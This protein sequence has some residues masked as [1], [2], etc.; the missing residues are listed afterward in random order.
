M[1]FSTSF[2]FTN[3]RF[4]VEGALYKQRSC[5]G[6]PRPKKI[7]DCT[8][9]TKPNGA[10]KEVYDTEHPH[11]SIRSVILAE[12]DMDGVQCIALAA[13]SGNPLRSRID[14]ESPYPSVRAINLITEQLVSALEHLDSRGIIHPMLTPDTIIW[15]GV[16]LKVTGFGVGGK[17]PTRYQSPAEFFGAPQTT[18]IHYWKLACI[19]YELVARRPL[20]DPRM[21]RINFLIGRAA[22]NPKFAA[23]Y[24]KQIRQIYAGKD[25]MAQEGLEPTALFA[26]LFCQLISGVPPK[27][28][29]ESNRFPKKTEPYQPIIWSPFLQL[30]YRKQGTLDKQTT[31]SPE[32]KTIM[33]HIGK[34]FR[35]IAQ[36]EPKSLRAITQ[37][38]KIQVTK[39]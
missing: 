39:V 25:F 4:Y 22:S 21:P 29:R 5:F 18:R 30:A 23:L 34:L 15:D 10:Q 12:A 19:V 24:T 9:I 13:L 32:E 20:L 16:Q 2:D 26:K 38:P 35:G 6:L 14:P 1:S 3:G 27:A 37:S 31:L 17:V 8:L 11:P 33:D 7:A 36:W 28:F